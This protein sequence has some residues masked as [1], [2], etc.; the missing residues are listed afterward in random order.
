MSDP[1][2]AAGFYME[3][4]VMLHRIK[5]RVASVSF[6]QQTRLRSK[7]LGYG[8]V[9]TALIAM[10]F[11][12]VV[13]DPAYGQIAYQSAGDGWWNNPSTWNPNGIPGPLDTAT[14]QGGHTVTLLFGGNPASVWVA[15]LVIN[16]NGV[17][18]GGIDA[19]VARGFPIVVFADNLINDGAIVG[20]PGWHS[21]G[22]HIFLSGNGQLINRGGI[23]AGDEHSPDSSPL[24]GGIVIIDYNE[25]RNFGDIDAGLRGG[26][27]DVFGG[28]I[29]NGDLTNVGRIRGADGGLV[30]GV[31][32][33]SGGWASVIGGESVTIGPE[34]EIR[35]GDGDDTPN[36]YGGL[37]FVMSGNIQVHQGLIRGGDG[38]SPGPAILLGGD[39]DVRGV[40]RAGD[41]T[42]APFSVVEAVIDPPEGEISGAAEVSAD[43]VALA[44]GNLLTI[45]P[46]DAAGAISAVGHMII[47]IAP[48][49]TLD[50]SNLTPGTYWLSAGD[51]VTI[52][53]DNI[54][55]PPGGGLADI[56][57]APTITTEV[58]NCFERLVQSPS[59]GFHLAAGQTYD[60]P[61]TV[62]NAGNMSQTVQ[63][64]ISGLGGWW[65]GGPIDRSQTLGPMESMKERIH[66][67][68]PGDAEPGS[69]AML[70]LS[71]STGTRSANI[72]SEIQVTVWGNQ[73]V[74]TV[75]ERGVIALAM[76]LLA[77]GALLASRRIRARA[78]A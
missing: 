65:Y 27:V 15:D 56:I 16:E 53:S 10:V 25:V 3:G 21:S 47:T 12:V 24:G 49:G 17:L 59:M 32:L 20:T 77:V 70:S 43:D 54:T 8:G 36:S 66:I 38:C 75:G 4:V 28:T 72:Q 44:A 60:L 13:A 30:P 76:L 48:G 5:K 40:V 2:L 45:G 19:T 35:A 62:I 63:W 61:V 11:L 31:G 29:L 1:Y 57:S 52:R 7:C 71:A 42:C 33:Y 18:T 78:K 22:G 51:S 68:I 58:G 39:K 64:H 69:T 26:V 74:S 37:A 55:L 41:W 73:S 67:V 46:L 6:E 9:A 14:I 23:C 34:S 50:M